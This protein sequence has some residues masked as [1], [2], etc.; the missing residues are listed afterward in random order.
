MPTPNNQ[1]VS[2][3]E[4]EQRLIKRGFYK[5]LIIDLVFVIL[6]VALYFANRAYGFLDALAARFS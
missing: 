3:Q 2:H 6:L 4:Q 5:A 1:Q